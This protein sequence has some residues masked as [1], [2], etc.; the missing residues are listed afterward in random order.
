M[1]GHEDDHHG[2]GMWGME[3]W[4]ECKPAI[5]TARNSYLISLNIDVSYI[6]GSTTIF[7]T[8]EGDLVVKL[9]IFEKKAIWQMDTKT[10]CNE[11]SWLMDSHFL[12]N[13]F[14]C[15]VSLLAL[16]VK[17]DWDAEIKTNYSKLMG[18]K[19]FAV[20]LLIWRNLKMYMHTIL[21]YMHIIHI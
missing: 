16:K 13:S 19:T 3:E 5:N 9:W 15:R 6:S 12:L 4:V 14:S 2:K 7:K 18:P 20:K 11:K 8:E 1:E 10:V 17:L 21:S